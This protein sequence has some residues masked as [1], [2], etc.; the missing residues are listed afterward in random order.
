MVKQELWKNTEH[1]MSFVKGGVVPRIYEYKN[2]KYPAWEKS[3]CS[4]KVKVWL[5]SRELLNEKEDH[6]GSYPYLR[7]QGNGYYIYSFRHNLVMDGQAQGEFFR[8][9]SQEKSSKPDWNIYDLEGNLLSESAVEKLA[10]KNSQVKEDASGKSKKK[11]INAKRPAPEK[12]DKKTENPKISLEE[13][14]RILQRNFDKL[15]EKYRNKFKIDF[16]G[17]EDFKLFFP[18]K[19]EFEKIVTWNNNV[20]DRSDL[21]DITGFYELCLGNPENA[22]IIVLGKNPGAGGFDRLKSDQEFE[23]LFEEMSL[24]KDIESKGCFFP[25]YNEDAMGFRPW[26]PGRLIFGIGVTR[27]LPDENRDEKR[28]ILSKFIRRTA[29]AS[30]FANKICSIDLVPYHTADFEHGENLIQVFGMVEQVLTPVRNAMKKRKIIL[31]PYSTTYDKWVKY[32]PE[33]EN[34]DFAYTTHRLEGQS[35]A[36]SHGSMHI[37]RLRHV[38][39]IKKERAANENCDA[40]FKR[41]KELGWEKI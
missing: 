27:R 18:S 15:Q 35:V 16:I 12:N 11:K 17:S 2:K 13:S 22:D 40:I 25:L 23:E 30:K 29:E 33:L 19:D 6:E 26:F 24:R 8:Y 1:L 9:F 41:L 39:N 37:D 38:K 31:F 4:S 28:G 36:D 21:I 7:A 14:K 34:Y 32:I 20:K 10:A 3:G 5:I